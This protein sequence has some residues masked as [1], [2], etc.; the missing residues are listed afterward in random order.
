MEPVPA[1]ASAA[2]RVEALLP[3]HRTEAWT[4][5]AFVFLRSFVQPSS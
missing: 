5:D 2:S 3:D 1:L 4:S